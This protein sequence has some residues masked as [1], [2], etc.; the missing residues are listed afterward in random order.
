MSNQLPQSPSPSHSDIG[1]DTTPPM[2]SYYGDK[3]RDIPSWDAFE[4]EDDEEIMD[5]SEYAYASRDHVL[6]CI[7]ASSSMQTPRPD[8]ST[9]EGIIRGKSALHQVMDAVMDLQRKKVITGPADSVGI[10]FWNID[11]SRPTTSAGSS[12]GYKPGTLVYQPLRTI[13]AEEMKRGIK[14][15]E[16]AQEEY[17]SQEETESTTQPDTLTEAFPACKKGEELKVAEVLQTCNHLFRDGGTKLIGN[18]RIF[19]ITD[20]DEPPGGTATFA[21]SRTSYSDL[22][23][24]GVTINT[25][26]IDRP[27]HRFNPSLYWNDILGR[28]TDEDKPDA[29]AE[30]EGLDKL[31]DLLTDLA[32]RNAPKRIQFSVPLRIG[33]EG[34]GIEIGISGYALVSTQTKGQPKYV[35]MRGQ[36][37]EEV[38]TKT[39]YTAAETG[40]VLR[41]EEIGHAFQFGHESTIRNVLEPNWWESSD[42][43]DKE[44]QAAEEALRRAKARRDAG[45]GDDEIDEEDIK[46][47]ISSSM[48][49]EEKSRVVARTRLA[50]KPEEVA[51]FKSMGI[52]PQIKI[53]GFQSPENINIEDNIKHSYFIYPD[54]NAYTGS[55]R[56]FAALLQS[57]IKLDR[58]ALALCRFR[59]NSTPEFAVLIPQEET[60]T[61]GGGQDMPPG[62]HVI[63]LP[64]IDDIRQAPKNMTENLVANERQAKLMSNIVKRLRN[65][66]GRY[67]SEVYPNPSLQYH[68]AQLQAL[69]FEEDFDLAQK[70]DEIDRTYPKYHGMH[71]AA[72]E[73]MAEWNQAIEE[74]ERAVES[75]KAPTKRAAATV[76]VDEA[77]LEDVAGAYREGT[78]DKVKVADLRAYAKFH[79]ISLSGKSAKKDIIEQIIPFL[80]TLGKKSKN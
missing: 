14:L 68:Y 64:F 10:M 77:E 17:E 76:E 47:R 4:A 36:E 27:D 20:N 5:S 74:D 30:P 75:L 23:T 32:I 31:A 29:G 1:H 42:R 3:P 52:T 73:F 49:Q 79:K 72:G 15:L 24:L 37:V 18:K 19:L 50:F 80:E 26:F 45:D 8:M 63:V 53:L 25:F 6:F 61:E 78:I 34:G 51:E 21:A 46:P 57:C 43:Q 54:E 38:V 28:E 60:F 55:T 69:A 11:P 67:R 71:K 2:S 13:N 40:A 16:H 33:K 65:K 44:Q 70:I 9:P 56:T 41:P 58:H 7:D 22:L 62:F 39:E 12:G 66:A 48:K 59:A 35:R